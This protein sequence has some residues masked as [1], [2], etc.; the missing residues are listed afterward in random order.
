MSLLSVAG[1]VRTD[2]V[3]HQR[4]GGW[5]LLVPMTV[6]EVGHYLTVADTLFLVNLPEDNASGG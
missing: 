2:T 4:H 5:L 1:V 3:S 6:G